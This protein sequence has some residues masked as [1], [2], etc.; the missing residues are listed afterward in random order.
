MKRQALLV[1]VLLCVPFFAV[2]A[3]PGSQTEYPVGFTFAMTVDPSRPAFAGFSGRPIPL[4]IFYPADPDAIGPSTPQAV[5]PFEPLLRPWLTSTSADWEK[6]GIARAYQEPPPSPEGPFPLVMFSPGWGARAIHHFHIAT[7]L[8]RHGFVV[9]VFSHAGDRFFAWEPAQPATPALACFHRPRD[10]SFA[11]SRILEMNVSS[12]AL[13]A[14]A[15]DPQR[16]AAGGW[17]LGGYAAM[18]LAAGDDLVCD[19]FNGAPAETCF[20]T[21]PDSRIKALLLLDGSN[22]V[23]RF[24]ELARVR[25]PALGIGQEWTTVNDWQARQHAAFAGHPSYR[26]DVF[27]TIHQSFANVCELFTVLGDTGIWTPAQVAARTALLCNNP[28]PTAE[29]RRLV[30]FYAIAFLRT[31]LNGATEYRSMLTPG[32]ALTNEPNIEFFVTEKRAAQAIDDDWPGYFTYF[33]HQ[34]GRA[35]AFGEKDPAVMR[36]VDL[37]EPDM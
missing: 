30:H 22:Q 16:I 25:V 11:L 21:A 37:I 35:Q 20:P 5:Y 10:V 28:L 31:V 15:I 1:S 24:Q 3:A 4:H 29:A 23:L 27:G 18:T 6:Y 26:V 8:A 14:N 7:Q 17:S 36:P 19:Q 34:P 12:T 32:W 33:M 9:A 2:S 13:L